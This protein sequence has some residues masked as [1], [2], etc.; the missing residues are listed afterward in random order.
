MNIVNERAG[1]AVQEW[2]IEIVK[3]DY[4][5]KVENA[6]KKQRQKAVIPG[7][8]PGKAP[9][10][11]VRKMYY[12]N[13]LAE[14]IDEMVRMSLFGYLQENKINIILEPLPVDEKSIT[15]FDNSEDFT[16]VFEFAV[17]PEF[18]IDY[19]KLPAVKDFKVTAS[20]KEIDEYINNLRKKFGN[21]T[22]PEKVEGHE[23]FITVKYGDDK[24]GFIHYDD[25]NT[26]GQKLFKGKK[27][28]DTF[29]VP[30][31]AIYDD[32]ELVARFLKVKFNE[33]KADNDYKVTG[34][35]ENI[36]KMDM[37][38][39]NEDFFQNAFP[40]GSVKNEN[41][42]K[43][44]AT[45]MIENQW[46]NETDRYFLN[47]AI[48]VLLDNVS[49][50]MPDDFIKRY[51][52]QTQD[53]MT[54]EKLDEEYGKYANTFKWQLIENKI[55]EANN[56]KVN[57]DEIRDHVKNFFYTHYFSQFN[58]D[59]IAEHLDSLV[60]DTLKRQEDVREIY[61]TL[62]DKKM[63]DVLR[64]KMNLNQQTGDFNEFVTFVTGKAP[65]GETDKPAKKKTAKSKAKDGE[66]KENTKEIREETKTEAT[67]EVV[68]KKK[69]TKKS[70]KK[71]E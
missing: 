46:E 2:K 30:V 15:D 12:K 44:N 13:F 6:L 4:S 8:R 18:E 31:N 52:L 36:G 50:A 1:E 51:L 42:L 38:E 26:K 54:Q 63:E 55:A 19:A 67:E 32:P 49:I 25:L 33:L 20:E 34:M 69:T 10:G 65:D 9:M 35:I 64:N 43:A 59:D 41:D 16:F 3:S 24:T 21:Y 22:N 39:L 11:M 53:G 61:D 17:K 62:F 5:E 37:A 45:E 56:I 48:G 58:I 14:E 7:F 68:V 28:N 66:V 71:E 60:K 40:D 29:D 57:E 23:E 27:V 70:T 47:N